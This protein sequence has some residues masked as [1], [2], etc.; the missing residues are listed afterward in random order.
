MLTCRTEYVIMSYHAK[1]NPDAEK[2]SI[3]N[4]ESFSALLTATAGLEITKRFGPSV[5]DF[6]MTNYKAQLEIG[7]F[8]QFLFLH[9]S[10]Y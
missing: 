1:E 7:I 8:A 9:H 5:C 4:E 10:T 3:I 2:P 6:E